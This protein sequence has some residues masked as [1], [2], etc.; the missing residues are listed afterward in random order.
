MRRHLFILLFALICSCNINADSFYLYTLTFDSPSNTSTGTI[1]GTDLYVWSGADSLNAPFNDFGQ[2]GGSFTELYQA[3]I[4]N[5]PNELVT[6]QFPAVANGVDY[7]QVG[8]VAVT[9]DG[10]KSIIASSNIILSKFVPAQVEDPTP[11][12]NILI[13]E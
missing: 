2:T 9:S 8:L 6:H 4:I 13:K 7:I 10:G 5:G 3:N 12:T 11:A 1:V